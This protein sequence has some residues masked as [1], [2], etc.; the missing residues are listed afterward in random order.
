MSSPAETR[1]PEFSVEA[2]TFFNGH[3]VVDAISNFPEFWIR[4]GP[5]V[6]WGRFVRL[7][8]AQPT[9]GAAQFVLREVLPELAPQQGPTVSLLGVLWRRQA[10]IEAQ[11]GISAY[12]QGLTQTP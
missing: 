11:Q 7:L 2:V 12:L 6:G 4:I 3:V 5:E 9:N 8:D 10:A 1:G